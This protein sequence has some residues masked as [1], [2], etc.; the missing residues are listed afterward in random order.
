MSFFQYYAQCFCGDNHNKHGA[1]VDTQC[2]TPCKGNHQQM[3]GG[4]WRLSIYGTG[5]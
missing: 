2:N 4:T 1:A 3:C 5:I